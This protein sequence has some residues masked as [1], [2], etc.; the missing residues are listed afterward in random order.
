LVIDVPVLCPVPVAGSQPSDNIA[1][2][3]QFKDSY[4]IPVPLVFGLFL[5]VLPCGPVARLK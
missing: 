1:S 4:V 5:V 2:R 3:L